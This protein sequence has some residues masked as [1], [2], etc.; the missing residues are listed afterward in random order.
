M[1]FLFIVILL[2]AALAA[3]EAPRCGG[4]RFARQSTDIETSV[5]KVVK[6]PDRLKRVYVR[7]VERPDRPAV[8]LTIVV[9]ARRSHARVAGTGVEILWSPDSRLLAVNATHCCD[10]LDPHLHLFEINPDGVRELEIAPVITR[11]FGKTLRCD[12]GAKAADLAATAA[13]KWLDPQRLLAAIRVPTTT[14][15]DSSGTFEVREISLPDMQVVHTYNQLQA[16]WEFWKLLGCDL[17]AANNDCIVKPKTCWVEAY[18][19]KRRLG[20]GHIP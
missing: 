1:R 15:C 14:V 18:H 5:T 10:G 2:T 13:L 7:R 11:D 8:A 16:K 6:A 4:P 9:G 19:G 12:K 3:Q 20:V 17:R